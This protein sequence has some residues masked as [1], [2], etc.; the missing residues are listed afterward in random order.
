MRNWNA[1]AFFLLQ[2]SS[3]MPLRYKLR[4]PMSEK[5]LIF[6]IALLSF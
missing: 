6:A 1:T 2:N 3:T 4:G 5:K